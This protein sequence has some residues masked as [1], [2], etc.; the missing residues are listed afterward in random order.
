MQPPRSATSART[1][2]VDATA[3]QR[4]MRAGPCDRRNRLA[5]L[6]AARTLAPPP[7]SPGATSSGSL[8][9]PPSPASTSAPGPC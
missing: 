6:H 5:A 8:R 2:A 1:L 3:L 7:P 4:D 9:P